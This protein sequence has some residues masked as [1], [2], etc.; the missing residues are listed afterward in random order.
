[1]SRDYRKL[2]VFHQADSLVIDIYKITRRFPREET[3]GLQSQLRRAAISSAANIVDGS[4]RRAEGE[5]L[6]FLNIAAG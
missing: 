3:Y 5:Y 2:R 6:N 1:M 4:A